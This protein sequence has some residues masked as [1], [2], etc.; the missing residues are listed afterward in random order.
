M[1]DIN[2]IDEVEQQC[3]IDLDWFY[4]STFYDKDKYL[5][6]L[7]EGIKCNEL[8]H[9]SGA[10][11]Y[12]GKYYISLSKITI[13]DN[14]CFLYYSTD[15]PSFIISGI[16]PIKCEGYEEYLKYI[17][18]KDS[19]RI[20]NF[21]DEYQYYYFIQNSHIKGIVYNLLEYFIIKDNS[22]KENKFDVW[23]DKLKIEHLLELIKLLDELDIEIPIYDYSRRDKLVAH[24]ID[25]EKIKYYSKDILL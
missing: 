10:G 15:T 6:I 17:N 25:K 22:K 1:V 18:T 19:R 21:S 7:T 5:S 4:H 24:E 12:N 13:P 9:R 16:E 11:V 8:L 23:F 3:E 2:I 20:G 14:N